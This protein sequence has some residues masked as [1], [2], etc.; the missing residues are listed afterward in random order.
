MCASA[1]NA[2]TD[3]RSAPPKS[4]AGTSLSSRNAAWSVDALFLSAYAGVALA[5]Q[6]DHSNDGEQQPDN[7]Q[8]GELLQAVQ[9]RQSQ[10]QDEQVELVVGHQ[11]GVGLGAAGHMVDRCARRA[12]AAQQA[13]GQDLVVFG[14]Q[15]AHGLSPLSGSGF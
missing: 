11:C 1:R 14:Y 9:A 2:P 4:N 12:Q 15:D 7:L 5:N 13:I 10:V 8:R 3:E 6:H